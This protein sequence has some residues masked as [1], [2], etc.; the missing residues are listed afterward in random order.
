[1]L[2]QVHLSVAIAISRLSCG[3][4]WKTVRTDAGS[5]RRSTSATA[6]LGNARKRLLCDA[7]KWS[8]N[9]WFTPHVTMLR[10]R[11]GAR[12]SER[13]YF[14]MLYVSPKNLEINSAFNKRAASKLPT[15]HI[16]QADNRTFERHEKAIHKQV[17][18][19]RRPVAC[20]Y[21]CCYVQ[22]CAV[23]DHDIRRFQYISLW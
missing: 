5:R 21:Q 17:T 15:Y 11:T 3:P 12:A 7:R 22:F 9:I 4:H 20:P 2:L 6:S 23:I 13:T 14:M 8:S 1:M 16:T 18:H 19:K 10:I